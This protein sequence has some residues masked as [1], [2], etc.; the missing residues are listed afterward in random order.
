MK[1]LIAE[2]DPVSRRVLEGTLTR[3]GHEVVVS[4]DGGEAWKVLQRDDPPL[5]AIMD[6]MMPEMDGLE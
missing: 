1:V 4:G 5:L 2:D 6:W 3:W